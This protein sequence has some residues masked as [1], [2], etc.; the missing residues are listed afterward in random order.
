MAAHE[1]SGER[2]SSDVVRKTQ[3]G[4]RCGAPLPSLKPIF[5]AITPMFFRYSSIAERRIAVIDAFIILIN[6][7]IETGQYQFYRTKPLGYPRG[8]G[9]RRVR[10]N[11]LPPTGY[12]PLAKGES[13]HAQKA[14]RLDTLLR[15]LGTSPILG[16]E[17]PRTKGH[18]RGRRTREGTRKGGR[19]AR[20]G[21]R[22]G[23]GRGR[24]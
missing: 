18:T 4:H 19:R 7:A 14:S 12:S 15:P 9:E 11:P 22:K 5:F 16:E 6:S 13:G 10:L 3:V 20:E 1:E 21:T 2:G 8:L 17:L 24:R 23:G